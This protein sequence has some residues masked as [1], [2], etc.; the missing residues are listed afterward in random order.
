[1]L[2]PKN[3]ALK[4]NLLVPIQ[5]PLKL[6]L[7]IKL[8]IRPCPTGDKNTLLLCLTFSKLSAEI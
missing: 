8:M 6:G 4:N 7:S 1:M 3:K 2:S 5:V